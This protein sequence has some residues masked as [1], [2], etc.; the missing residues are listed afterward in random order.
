MII[1]ELLQTHSCRLRTLQA[2]VAP[3]QPPVARTHTA[4]PMAP[5]PSPGASVEEKINFLHQQLDSI[6]LESTILSGLVLLGSSPNQRLQ[7]GV[8][9][10]CTSMQ[11]S[12]QVAHASHELET[13][14]SYRAAVLANGSTLLFCPKNAAHR[15]MVGS[16]LAFRCCKGLADGTATE[17]VCNLRTSNS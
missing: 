4:A 15:N 17:K 5:P 14:T 6:G 16:A 8:L 1:Q 2:T 7:G 10:V 3:R 13:Y 12:T 11:S 9:A